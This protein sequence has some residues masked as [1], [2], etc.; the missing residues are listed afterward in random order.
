[1][2]PDGPFVQ[3]CKK[4][5]SDIL[6][7]LFRIF[8]QKTLIEIFL[9][10]EFVL[11]I[12]WEVRWRLRFHVL[13]KRTLK[14]YAWTVL[15]IRKTIQYCFP[16]KVCHLVIFFLFIWLE[17]LTTMFLTQKF[18]QFFV[19]FLIYTKSQ[20]LCLQ[21]VSCCLSC[22]KNVTIKWYLNWCL[23]SFFG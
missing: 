7:L 10:K 8:Q 2:L 11:I 21:S 6:F 12:K 13:G 19:C 4:N 9:K 16:N 5:I 17:S 20:F 15:N 14:S 1:L 18:H 22:E 3:P 23:S